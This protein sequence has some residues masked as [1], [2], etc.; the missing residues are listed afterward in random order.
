MQPDHPLLPHLDSDYLCILFTR[1][2]DH[3]LHQ[4]PCHLDCVL[5]G[6]P[7]RGGSA[8]SS[9][10]FR[11]WSISCHQRL[12]SFRCSVATLSRQWFS[13]LFR[14]SFQSSLSISDFDQA[15]LTKCRRGFE[16]SSSISCQ[17]IVIYPIQ[18]IVYLFRILIMKR[19][20]KKEAVSETNKLVDPIALVGKN[21]VDDAKVIMHWIWIRNWQT[22]VSEILY[23]Y[24]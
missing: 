15:L 7:R 12:S 13:C 3:I 1:P 22:I 14:Q 5:L 20:V 21:Y 10:Q 19:P 16:Q 2:Q 23:A 17:S 8:E 9:R 11:F 24:L 4:H 6:R 18:I